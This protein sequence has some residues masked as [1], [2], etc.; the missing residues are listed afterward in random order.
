M[1]RRNERRKGTIT[2]PKI[3]TV[4]R[5]SIINEMQAMCKEIT[6]PIKSLKI[7][8]QPLPIIHYKVRSKSNHPDSARVRR[9]PL[10]AEVSAEEQNKM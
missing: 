10:V 5:L 8:S 9:H 7:L 3:Q 1:G 6:L 2:R 4:W